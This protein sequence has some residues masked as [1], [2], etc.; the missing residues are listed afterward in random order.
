MSSFAVGEFLRIGSSSRSTM[1]FTNRPMILN[2]KAALDGILSPTAHSKLAAQCAT[3][4][5]AFIVPHR[6]AVSGRN[7]AVR[8]LTSSTLAG[9]KRFFIILGSLSRERI[10]IG[11]WLV[12][13]RDGNIEQT[14]IHCTAAHSV[15]AY[16]PVPCRRALSASLLAQQIVAVFL[17][18]RPTLLSPRCIQNIVNRCPSRHN[19]YIPI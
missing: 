18:M 12:D 2:G 4:C 13:R 5:A 9:S 16:C 8:S 19:L 14:K 6:C 17:D 7:C 10:L 3:A 1:G 11:A 15:S